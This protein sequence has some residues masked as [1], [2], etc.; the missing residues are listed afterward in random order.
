M[1]EALLFLLTLI[2]F[3]IIINRNIAGAK[4]IRIPF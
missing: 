4:G 1:R 3:K 2:K